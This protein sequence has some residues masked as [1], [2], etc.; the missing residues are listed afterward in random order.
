MISMPAQSTQGV[1]RKMAA[2][3]IMPGMA[4]RVGGGYNYHYVLAIL[5][6]I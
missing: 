5:R 6:R 1:D 2:H 3:H 4:Y